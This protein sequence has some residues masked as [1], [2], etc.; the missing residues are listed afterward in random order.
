MV[1]EGLP[2]EAPGK[3]LAVLAARSGGE[4]PPGD[5]ACCTQITG[6]RGRGETSGSG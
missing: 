1:V 2:D 6:S 3:L 4:L 5:G